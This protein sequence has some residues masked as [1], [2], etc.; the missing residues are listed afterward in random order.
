LKLN[1]E[2]SISR[3]WHGITLSS[4]LISLTVTLNSY[5]LGE[6]SL[7]LLCSLCMPYQEKTN[8]LRLM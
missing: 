7:S 5:P 4:L 8:W 1:S 3:R 2:F 6:R